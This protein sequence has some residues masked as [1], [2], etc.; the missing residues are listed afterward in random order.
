MYL[1]LNFDFPWVSDCGA[2]NQEQVKKERIAKY[3]G[4]KWLC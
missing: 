2:I 1:C 3:V 4:G